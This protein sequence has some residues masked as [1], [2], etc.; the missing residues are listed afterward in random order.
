[1]ALRT[2]HMGGK[3]TTTAG[4]DIIAAAASTD[5]DVT[6]LWEVSF[7]PFADCTITINGVDTLAVAANT[8]R[9]YGK[10]HRIE[11]ITVAEADITYDLDCF[12]Y[13]EK[14][15]AE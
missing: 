1:M 7:I 3:G 4:L 13:G 15:D 5:W 10:D 12:V 9:T 2:G 14:A 6:E 8:L 11:S